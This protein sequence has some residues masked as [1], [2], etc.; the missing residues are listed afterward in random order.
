MAHEE[1]STGHKR[2]VFL[3]LRKDDGRVLGRVW[4]EEKRPDYLLDRIA[5]KL[6]VREGETEIVAFQL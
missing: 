2:P 1:D 5:G 3:K 4:L 6:Y